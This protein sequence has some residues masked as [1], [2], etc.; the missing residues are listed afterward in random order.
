MSIKGKPTRCYNENNSNAINIHK[1]YKQSIILAISKF[2]KGFF[3]VLSE[4]HNILEYKQKNK[5]MRKVGH[6]CFT[7]TH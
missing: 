2:P 6:M 1:S 5:W 4:T 7:N 3:F